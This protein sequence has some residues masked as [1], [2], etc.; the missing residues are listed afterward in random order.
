MRNMN[1]MMNNSCGCM[2]NAAVPMNECVNKAS[3]RRSLAE[4]AF[5]VHEAVLYLDTHPQD[6]GAMEYF[7]RKKEKYCQIKEQFEAAEGPLTAFS[8]E[9]NGGDWQWIEGPW[10]WEGEA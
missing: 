2:D 9:V 1:T 10:P 7:A 5:A 8:T 4:A 3:L 6:T